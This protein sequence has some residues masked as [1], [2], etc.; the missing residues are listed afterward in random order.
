DRLAA[1]L[2]TLRATWSG[3]GADGF[4]RAMFALVARVLALADEAA[5]VQTGLSMM[6][7]SLRL[8]QEA[9]GDLPRPLGRWPVGVLDPSWG[10]TRDDPRSPQERLARVVAD[11]ALQYALIERKV[12][13]GPQPERSA[14]PPPEQTDPAVRGTQAASA[15][16]PRAVTPMAGAVVVES[17]HASR[18]TAPNATSAS[19]AYGPPVL[20]MGMMGAV[21]GV[22]GD[23]ARGT[24]IRWRDGATA[25]MSEEGIE[26]DSE[27]PPV[28]DRPA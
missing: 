15:G 18:L 21:G 9:A 26:V 1:G 4:E 5:A 24:A 27:A 3:A 13:Y 6:S 10:Y 25:W 11:L 22:S 14:E 28:V 2:R 17:P 19:G 12:W 7:A 16:D 20:P 23:A 8:A